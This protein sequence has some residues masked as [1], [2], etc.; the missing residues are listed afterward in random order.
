MKYND[1][2]FDDKEQEVEEL[3][4]MLDH[5]DEEIERLEDDNEH[6]EGIISS[7][8]SELMVFHVDN[9]KSVLECALKEEKERISHLEQAE[10]GLKADISRYKMQCEVSAETVNK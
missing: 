1:K 6:K 4:G 7:L 8:K 5:K 3:Q 2:A 10:A 9:S